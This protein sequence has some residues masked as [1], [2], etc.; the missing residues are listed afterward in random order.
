MLFKFLFFEVFGLL[1]GFGDL[2]FLFFDDV[3][4]NDKECVLFVVMK[5]F[6][7]VWMYM[8]VMN[9]RGRVYWV[10]NRINV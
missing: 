8:K 9:V 1:F 10:R 3:D 4:E 2:F 7:V 5:R 6:F